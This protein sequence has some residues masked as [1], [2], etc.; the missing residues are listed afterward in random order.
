MMATLALMALI[1]SGGVPPAIELAAADPGGPSG[2][3]G[4]GPII[5]GANG[6]LPDGDDV[7]TVPPPKPTEQRL[8]APPAHKPRTPRVG[9]VR[10]VESAPAHAAKPAPKPS[11]NHAPTAV[12]KPVPAPDDQPPGD[13][14]R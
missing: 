10:G 1:M 8:K 7:Q 13:A 3:V 2:A 12:P 6:G 14:P 11:P 4:G 5:P 9:A